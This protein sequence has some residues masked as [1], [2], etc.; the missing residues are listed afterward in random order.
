VSNEKVKNGNGTKRQHLASSSTQMTY[1][2]MED[3]SKSRITFP[4]TKVVKIP[5]QRHNILMLLD[6]PYE[7]VEAVITSPKQSQSPTIAK[8]RGKIPPFYISIEN[9]DVALHNCL[10]DT[11]ATNNIMPLAVMEVSSMICTKYYEI[12][13]SIYVVDS[14]KVP[15]YREINDFYA[16]ITTTPHIITIFNIIVVDIPPTYRVVLGRDWTST[17]I[18][19]IMNDES[20]MILLGK[21]GAMIKVPP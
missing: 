20:C 9:H 10:V 5:Q 6:D 21:E 11:S 2:V 19:Y 16:W 3:L 8:V 18:G 12:G 13:E 15:A 14:T 17:I 7:S 4:F 1:N